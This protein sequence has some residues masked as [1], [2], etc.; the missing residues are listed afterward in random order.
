[1]SEE[2]SQTLFEKLSILLG[3]VQSLPCCTFAKSVKCLAMSVFLC[4]KRKWNPCYYSGQFW[5]IKRKKNTSLFFHLWSNN[6]DSNQHH[7]HLLT[8]LLLK[9][10]DCLG[11]PANAFH[12]RALSILFHAQ[13]SALGSREFFLHTAAD[14][15]RHMAAHSRASLAFGERGFLAYYQ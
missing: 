9:C 3:C 14:C 1:M 11:N 15:S 2:K 6:A 7:I 5:K 10:F 13:H 12:P 8:P 4:F